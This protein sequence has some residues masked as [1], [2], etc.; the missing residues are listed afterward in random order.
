MTLNEI[1]ETAYSHWIL[2]FAFTIFL[3]AL[4][5]TIIIFISLFIKAIMSELEELDLYTRKETINKKV[6]FIN[7]KLEIILRV[8]STLY[9]RVEKISN[10]IYEHDEII[11]DLLDGVKKDVNNT[12]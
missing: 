12:W 3:I 7:Q 8:Q 1:F 9:D 2:G 10:R 6:D 11:V 4:F 5:I